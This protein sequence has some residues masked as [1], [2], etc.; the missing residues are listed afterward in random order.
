MQ[1]PWGAARGR[2]PS[3]PGLW[4][5]TGSCRESGQ[6]AQRQGHLS[7]QTRWGEEDPRT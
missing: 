6:E 4:T 5:G 1:P 2:E 7:T 3:E